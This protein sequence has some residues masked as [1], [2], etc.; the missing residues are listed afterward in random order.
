MEGYWY[1]KL[2]ILT[3]FICLGSFLP[4][5]LPTSFLPF[6]LP[7]SFPSLLPLI[8]ISLLRAKNNLQETSKSCSHLSRWQK[9]CI[10]MP[11]KKEQKEVT[12]E[13]SVGM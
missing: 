9:K 3:P 10:M 2:C 12:L 11:A 1:L 4:S 6:F 5:F 7:P 8:V 13:L